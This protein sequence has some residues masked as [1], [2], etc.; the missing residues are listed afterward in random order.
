MTRLIS[1]CTIAVMRFSV[2]IFC[3]ALISTVTSMSWLSA[4]NTS[5]KTTT[6]VH[7]VKQLTLNELNQSRLPTPE[8][9]LAYQKQILPPKPLLYLNRCIGGKTVYNKGFSDSR[10]DT[11]T[12]PTSDEVHLS[13]YPH[14][15]ES[16]NQVVSH[17]K[18]M[19]DPFDIEVTE[20]DPGTEIS[21][22]EIFVCGSSVDVLQSDILGVAIGLP[23]ALIMNG[24]SFVF[25]DGA[26]NTLLLAKVI[27]HELGHNL[28]LDHLY[29]C[30][31]IMGYGFPDEDTGQFC[32]DLA[33]HDEAIE[34]GTYNPHRCHT[35]SETQN[36]YKIIDSIFNENQDASIQLVIRQTNTQIVQGTKLKIGTRIDFEVHDP[37]GIMALNV[38][39]DDQNIYDKNFKSHAS[40]T[41]K[42]HRLRIPPTISL[43]YHILSVSVTDALGNETNQDIGVTVL[44]APPESR[45]P[46]QIAVLSPTLNEVVSNGFEVNIAVAAPNE[47]DSIYFNVDLAPVA[48]FFEESGVTSAIYSFWVPHTELSESTVTKLLSITTVDRFG[49][50]NYESLEVQVTQVPS[51]TISFSDLKHGH[52][53]HPYQPV[54]FNARSRNAD[55]LQSISLYI[56]YKKIAHY[57][58]DTTIDPVTFMIPSLDTEGAIDIELRARAINGAVAS[59]TVTVNYVQ[60]KPRLALPDRTVPRISVMYP[61][62]N[63]R[64]ESG[65]TI[66]AD[67]FDPD[68]VTSVRFFID[69][70]QVKFFSDGSPYRFTTPIDLP[71]GKHRIDIIAT[72]SVGVTS[73][74]SRIV[75][76]GIDPPQSQDDSNDVSSSND[77]LRRLGDICTTGAQ[78]ASQQCTQDTNLCTQSCTTTATCPLRFVCTESSEGTVCLPEDHVQTTASSCSTSNSQN[79]IYI[80]IVLLGLLILRRRQT[81]VS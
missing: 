12:I 29:D 61:Q 36:S 33:F 41:P 67:I 46:P 64:V 7:Q 35:E 24:I 38:R 56:N 30:K 70:A 71:Q 4:K 28:T 6:S 76:L 21:H 3:F 18:D 22:H 20:T 15:D 8:E 32:G 74:E 78:C 27:S 48:T 52:I 34:C 39:I 57:D 66:E 68:G 45:P 72:D 31:A 10:Q 43:G 1:L 19:L 81:I 44:S 23:F 50:A 69:N 5:S 54:N 53:V 40:L 26:T 75:Y 77:D 73:V 65:F 13:E 80:S 11:S 37:N 14:G 49:K 62:S 63:S 58:F 60:Q 42:T 25:P 59:E 9:K 55:G 79:L 47:I 16:W 2:Y 17:V 51:P